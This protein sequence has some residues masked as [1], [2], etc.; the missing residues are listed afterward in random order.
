MISVGR[1][2]EQRPQLLPVRA[3]VQQRA[4]D[5]KH[6]E[7]LKNS[8]ATS[9]WHHSVVSYKVFSYPSSNLN[10]FHMTGTIFFFIMYLLYFWLC[11][12]FLAVPGLSLVTASG[13]SSPVAVN[14]LLIVVASHVSG[15]RAQ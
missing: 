7:S 13:G 1:K 8:H 12:V 9:C 15:A 4:R 14:R 10:P 6:P 5:R 3:E 2:I 11:R